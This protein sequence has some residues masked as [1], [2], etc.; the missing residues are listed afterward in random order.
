MSFDADLS[1]K[2]PG[3]LVRDLMR[4]KDKQ[5]A[6]VITQINQLAPDIL[7]LQSVDYDYDHVAIGLLK[8]AL[9]AAGHPMP[10]HYSAAPNTGVPTGFD[11]DRN[12]R[13]GE[14]RDAQGYGKFRGQGGMV[15]LS[16]FPVLTEHVQDFTASIWADFPDA[17]MPNEYFLQEEA[18]I[19][20]L[21]SVGA[22]DVPVRTSDGVVHVLM[23]K[24]GPPVFDGPEDRN[25]L[26]N[27][28][29]I[30]FWTRHIESSDEAFVI[31]AGLNNDPVKGEGLKPDLLQLL[32]SDRLSDPQP[33]SRDFGPA[34]VNWDFGKLRVDY[35]LPSATF[36]V[37]ASG[38]EWLA[39]ETDATYGSRHRPVW[40][41]IFW[42]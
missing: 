6:A 37:D 19:L 9:A 18:A 12:D 7:A 39:T 34:T 16:R 42:K 2:G 14:A 38:V 11:L 20:R 31:M 25:G 8:E 22:W 33:G 13:L 26:R 28:D 32:S 17:Q 5:I 1:R 36:G 23:S 24:A 41:D 27:G 30:R 15:L 10:H 4:G 29:E 21:H 40:V 3:L 35:V